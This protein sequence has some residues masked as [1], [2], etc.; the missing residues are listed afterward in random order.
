MNQTRALIMIRKTTTIII[1]T[2]K[3]VIFI[4]GRVE[5]LGDESIPQKT[6]FTIKADKLL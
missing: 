3:N 2:T 4:R 5:G 6:R 1:Q